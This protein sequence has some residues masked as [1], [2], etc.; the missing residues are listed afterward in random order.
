MNKLIDSC[1][2]ESPDYVVP[3]PTKRKKAIKQILTLPQLTQWDS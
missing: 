1:D 2:M 3:V